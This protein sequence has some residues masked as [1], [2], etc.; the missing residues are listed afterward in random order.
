MHLYDPHGAHRSRCACELGSYVQAICRILHV[1][2]PGVLVSTRHLPP[3]ILAHGE[4]LSYSAQV[5]FD[6][7][8]ILAIMEVSAR[9][10]T[11]KHVHSV[12]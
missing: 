4:S 5:C 3:G 2:F 1:V 9:A 6:V 10:C 12:Q 7:L 8:E 11:E